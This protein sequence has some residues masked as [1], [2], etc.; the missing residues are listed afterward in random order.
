MPSIPVAPVINTSFMYDTSAALITV[1]FA[2]AGTI[3]VAFK[4][5]PSINIPGLSVIV[6][7]IN[8]PGPIFTK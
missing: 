2:T 1:L 8:I 6:L 4:K 5:Y 3:V 7:S